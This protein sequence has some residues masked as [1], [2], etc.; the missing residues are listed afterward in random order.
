MFSNPGKKLLFVLLV[1]TV[2]PVMSFLLWYISPKNEMEILIVN[3]SVSSV[4][5]NEHKALFWILRYH[6]YVRSDGKFYNHKKDYYGF[7]PLRPY[8]DKDFEINGIRI[9]DIDS[10]AGHYDMA[11]F[12]DNH[13]V[14]FGDWYGD[15]SS[16]TQTRFLENDP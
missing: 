1:I 13:G 9:S 3:K 12:V 11:W 6:R 5:R 10:L 7:M 8:R 15:P 16:D 14:S 4:S 2:I